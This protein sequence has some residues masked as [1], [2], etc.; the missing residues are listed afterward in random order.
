VS[1]LELAKDKKQQGGRANAIF[2]IL[3]LNFG[4][5]VADHLLQVPLQSLGYLNVHKSK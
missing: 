3:M 5:Y 2:W 4:L 1:E